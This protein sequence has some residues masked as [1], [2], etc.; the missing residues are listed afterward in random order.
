MRIRTGA[1]GPA[2]LL[3]VPILAVISLT[4]VPAAASDCGASPPGNGTGLARPSNPSSLPTGSPAPGPEILHEPLA[5]TPQFENT[6]PWRGT[7]TMVSGTEV[8]RRGEFIATDFLYDDLAL[9]YPDQPERLA[10]NA[11]DI[12]EVRLKPLDDSLAIRVVLNSMLDVEATGITFALGGDGSTHELPHGAGAVAP[13]EV[14]V[15]VRGCTGDVVDASTGITLAP[16]PSVMVD[17]ERR[18]VDV[19]VPY[20][21]FDPRGRR[22][23]RV[24]AAAGLWDADAGSYL[25]PDSTLPAF[26]NVAFRDIGPWIMNTWME[27]TQNEVLATGDLSPLFTTVDFTALTDDVTDDRSG[28][29]RGLPTSGPMNRILV[30]HFEPAQG[31][32]NHAGGDILGDIH[33]DLP[34]CTYQYSGRLQPYSIYVP[35]LPPHEDGYA[36]VVNLHGA[37]SNHNQVGANV[38]TDEEALEIWRQLAEEGGRPAIMAMPNQRGLTYFSFGLAGT[39]MFEMWA[40][41]AAHYDLDPD[42]VVQSGAS[43]GGFGSYKA[44]VQFPDLYTALFPDVG[45]STAGASLPPYGN[46]IGPA[47]DAWRMFPSL[48]EIPVLAVNAHNDPIVNYGNTGYS[49]ETLQELG[50][51]HDFRWYVEPSGAGHTE[52]R[53]LVLDEYATL[54]GDDVFTDRDPWRVTYVLNDLMN[55]PEYGLT[56]DHAYWLSDLRLA[57]PAELLG[58]IDVVS[59]GFGVGDPPATFEG[60]AFG[61]GPNGLPTERRSMTWDEA[62]TAP[63]A[64]RLDITADNVASVTIDVDRARVSCNAEVRVASEAP[65]EVTL[66]GT[67]CTGTP[68]A[69]P[70]PGADVAGPKHGVRPQ[71]P[72]AL[73]V[74]GG[75][76]AVIGVLVMAAAARA[77]R[78]S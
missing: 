70:A 64:D 56:A 54:V 49:Q 63:V 33:C 19:R 76:L 6:G 11:A 16:T 66:V 39:D 14:F 73:P 32:G 62:P 71:A 37:N 10:G 60:P 47:G 72:P 2:F 24:A 51:R 52:F 9:T 75:G 38:S 1:I 5:R 69:A 17:L 53:H 8:I 25:R 48:R 50:Y 41:V 27:V 18:Q 46:I 58:T 77:R 40:D 78:R 42:R 68:A 31:R 28:Q 12:V 3:A 13:G 22:D 15:T 61:V 20:T 7:P 36:L 29:P 67:A 55:Q 57:D 74:T 43:M 26:Y 21:A 35:K 4:A 45:V 34:D 44:A 23:V 30:S 65:V 59:H